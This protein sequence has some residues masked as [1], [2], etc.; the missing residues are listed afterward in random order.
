MTGMN[1]LLSLEIAELSR[2]IVKID[3]LQDE[4]AIADL[5]SGME[6][7]DRKK[8]TDV[9]SFMRLN[10]LGMV[11]V[12]EGEA[13]LTIDY[14]PYTVRKNSFI[15]FM[16][17][18]IIHIAGVSPSFKARL[19]IVSKEFLENCNPSRKTSLM[20]H[21][22]EIKKNPHIVLEAD[23]VALL[24]EHLLLLREKIKQCTHFFHRDV[25]IN[26]LCGFFLELGNIFAGKLAS[27]PNKTLSRKEELFNQ[28][29][30]LL[31]EHCKEEHGVIFY[32]KKLFITPQYLSLILKELTGK[33]TNK[34]IDDALIT[35]AKILLKAPNT[36][37]QQV[38]DQLNFSDQ[39]TFGKF[40]K[41]HIGV[42]PIEYRKSG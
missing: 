32:S 20:L 6:M 19:L 23:E 21:Y 9:S 10:A 24:D 30:Q 11:V 25:V 33:S 26:T 7:E 3:S 22:M 4:F 42:S 8:F 13:T 1:N 12:L 15:T 40:F 31:V 5:S 41:K 14:M 27:L 2:R 16:P 17:T 28:F 37:V 39:S 29:L 34:W 36:T 35:E 38:A 18:H